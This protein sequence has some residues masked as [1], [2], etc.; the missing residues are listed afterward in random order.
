MNNAIRDGDLAATFIGRYVQR[1]IT[2]EKIAKRK[3]SAIN[4]EEF[5]AVCLFKGRV[6][7]EKSR[8]DEPRV[9]EIELGFE[10]PEVARRV[11]RNRLEKLDVEL[12]PL[13]L[14]VK[15]LIPENRELNIGSFSAEALFSGFL[16]YIPNERDSLGSK[17]LLKEQFEKVRGGAKWDQ[18]V[19]RFTKMV[20]A[21]YTNDWIIVLK[22]GRRMDVYTIGA[23][24]M[25]ELLIGAIRAGPSGTVA[26]LN[27]FEAHALR[28]ELDPIISKAHHVRIDLIGKSTRMLERLEGVISEMESIAI[29][30][31]VGVEPTL[32]AKQLLDEKMKILVDFLSASRPPNANV[33]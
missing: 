10:D 5:L 3:V 8:I 22:A 17:P 19:E 26:F 20:N 31:L 28:V 29:D 27:R 9:P 1:N 6:I 12:G 13:R 4:F 2:D 7:S 25:R 21:I 32:K 11:L 14:S 16:P 23:E 33:N 30:G 15:T 24:N 18:F